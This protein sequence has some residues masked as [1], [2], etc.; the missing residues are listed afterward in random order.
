M[1]LVRLM[2]PIREA[3][4]EVGF[5]RTLS[6]LSMKCFTT[7]MPSYR[8]ASFP[9]AGPAETWAVSFGPG[10]HSKEWIL[11]FV[12]WA[13]A[14]STNPLPTRF[15]NGEPPAIGSP[16]ARLP[17]ALRTKA[18]RAIGNLRGTRGQRQFRSVIPFRVL[19]D[20]LSRCQFPVRSLRSL[21]VPSSQEIGWLVR[22][23]TSN[24]NA[25]LGTG[26]WE[27]TLMWFVSHPSRIVRV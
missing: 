14:P 20:I 1:A 6:G 22:P 19:S 5:R 27:L 25:E 8:L 13:E 18:R 7:S 11:P 2:T 21:P 26:N 16:K 9:Q 10:G 4:R 17:G 23:G 3:P 24:P 15:P 12:A